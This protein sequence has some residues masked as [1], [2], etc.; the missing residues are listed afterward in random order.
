MVA[1]YGKFSR[2][3]Q[4]SSHGS[5]LG[6]S[7]YLLINRD[8]YYGLLSS[9]IY[10]HIKQRI[11]SYKE[12]LGR[13]PN[14]KQRNPIYPYNPYIYPPYKLWVGIS[15]P[16]TPRNPWVTEAPLSVSSSWEQRRSRPKLKP[17]R[18]LIKW[19]ASALKRRLKRLNG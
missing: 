7:V 1:F 8:P 14:I 11:T 15:S 4:K 17:W 19:P 16:K 6:T 9:P 12:S 5:V 10:R 18:P 2:Q 13:N 3:I